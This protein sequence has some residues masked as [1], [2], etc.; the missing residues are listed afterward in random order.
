MQ[1]ILAFLEYMSLV[2]IGGNDSSGKV[3][4]PCFEF[5]LWNIHESII[6]GIP[7][8]NN[9]IEAWHR[10][11]N[12]TVEVSRPNMALFL[13]CISNEEE[14]TRANLIQRKKGHFNIKG[15]NAN[16]EYRLRDM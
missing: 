8:T 11:I 12:A 9:S 13:T 1:K 2:Y 4:K 10:S 14:S 15:V 5:D 3:L 6:R 16:Y 7:R